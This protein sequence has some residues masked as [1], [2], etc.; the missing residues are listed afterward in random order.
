VR[1]LHEEERAWLREALREAWSGD[2]G[3][4]R[5]PVVPRRAASGP[6]IPEIDNGGIP[7]RDEIDLVRDLEDA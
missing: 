7:M 3:V 2:A 1:E 6:S 4:L 5:G